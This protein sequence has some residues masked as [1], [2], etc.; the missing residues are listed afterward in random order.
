[1]KLK[2]I[3]ISNYKS[4]KELTIPFDTQ[5]N[6]TN[7]DD[8]PSS[9]YGLIGVNEAGKSSILDSYSIDRSFN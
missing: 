7:P 2:A 5:E 9:T 3:T 4:I 1:M 6:S 8:N